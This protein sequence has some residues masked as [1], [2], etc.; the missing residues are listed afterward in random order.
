[1]SREGR[2]TLTEKIEIPSGILNTIIAMYQIALSKAL[3]SGSAALTQLILREATKLADEMLGEI[4]FEAGELESIDETIKKLFTE[5][6]ISN[7]VEVEKP[8][9]G[10]KAGKMYVIKIYDSIFK[11]VAILLAKKGIKFTLSPESFIAAYIIQ[12]VVQKT[13]PSAKVRI[14]IEPMKSPEEPLVIKVMIR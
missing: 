7:K 10:D 13:N 3:G 2:F 5:L 8:S 11:P 6:G 4:E 12:K 1:M 9:N 14:N